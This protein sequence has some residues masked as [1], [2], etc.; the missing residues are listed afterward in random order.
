M[1]QKVIYS[2]FVFLS[3]KLS[4]FYVFLFLE[5]FLDELAMVLWYS[6]KLDGIFSNSIT[7]DGDLDSQ[8]W[9]SSLLDKQTCQVVNCLLCFDVGMSTFCLNPNYWLMKIKIKI[10]PQIMLKSFV[11]SQRF[12]QAR[13][14]I[15]SLHTLFI[16]ACFDTP[17][18]EPG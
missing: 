5:L 12:N 7:S 3:L 6:F 2:I 18:H 4:N 8:L 10:K 9:N 11:N 13:C 14:N 17:E 15:Q 1:L 16:C